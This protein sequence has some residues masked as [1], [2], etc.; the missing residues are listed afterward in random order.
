MQE[1]YFDWSN[2]TEAEAVASLAIKQLKAEQEIT[3]EVHDM[4]EKLSEE[5]KEQVIKLIVQIVFEG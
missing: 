1:L 5:T 4:Y 3:K 2:Q